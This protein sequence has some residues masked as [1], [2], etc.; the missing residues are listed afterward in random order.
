MIEQQFANNADSITIDT[1]IDAEMEADAPSPSTIITNLPNDWYRWGK[2]ALRADNIPLIT[3][4]AVL[5]AFTVSVDRE[6]WQPFD[7][8]YKNN[9]TFHNFTETAVF[10]GDGK[11]QFG[12]AAAFA[13]YGYFGNDKRALRTAFQTTEVILACGGVVQLI[14]HATGRERPQANTARTGVWDIFP[15]QVKYHKSIP[16]YDAFPSGHF[17]TA[18]AT[19]TVIAENYPEAKWIRYVGYPALGC[20][21]VGLVSKGMHW[22]S[23]FP[24]A[25]A[26]GYSFGKIVSHTPV[27]KEVKNSSPEIMPQ[28]GLKLNEAALPEVMFSWK[29]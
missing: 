1:S 25:F 15:D 13:A 14:K 12:I 24:L 23:D 18:L 10:V 16:K 2:S 27:T 5:T 19:L 6:T 26:L 4:I 17:A 11:F 20:V 22:W 29:L 8:A 28:I 7:R 9:N 21:A 3:G